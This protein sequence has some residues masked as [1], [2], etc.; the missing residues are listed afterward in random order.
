[1]M[2]ILLVY[3]YFEILFQKFIFVKIYGAYRFDQFQPMHSAHFWKAEKQINRLNSNEIYQY[4]G[5]KHY[6]SK[7]LITWANQVSSA[8]NS[9]RITV[10][11][12]IGSW[13]FF[14]ATFL[15]HSINIKYFWCETL[16][17]SS[18]RTLHVWHNKKSWKH[19]K[20]KS[21]IRIT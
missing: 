12:F 11:N 16:W 18:H 7:N 19:N 5:V 1:M 2:N 14:S 3:F 13:L 10:V 17:N 8:S 15:E 21:E 4:F 9:L 20:T 6:L